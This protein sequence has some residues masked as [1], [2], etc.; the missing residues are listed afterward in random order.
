MS[1]WLMFSFLLT[2]FLSACDLMQARKAK[3]SSTSAEHSPEPTLA[4]SAERAA[5]E[6]TFQKEGK[7][8]STT[9]LGDLVNTHGIEEWEAYDPY[10]KKKK[11]WHTIKL[12]PVLKSM[13]N[14]DVETIRTKSF[15]MKASDGYSVPI[16]GEQLITDDAYLAV[17]DLDFPEW[18]LAGKQKAN[19]GPIY[20][21]WKQS[22]HHDLHEWPRPW[23]L[24]TI[25]LA[26]FEQT[27]PRTIPNE[28]I[29]SSPEAKG[30]EIFKTQCV[31]CHAVNQHGGRLGPE[32]NIPQNI[33]EYRPK[34]QIL[35]YIKNPMTFRYGSMP[36]FEH[37]S[38]QDLE[39]VY[40]YLSVMKNQKWTPEKKEE[41]L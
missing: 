23:Q 21:V 4:L 2:L 11:R 29:A 25:D 30:F 6:L 28:L 10:Y 12:L 13:F 32:L 14:M 27:F 33:T 8:L 41:S 3:E 18:E 34:E 24:T 40:A 38:E 26:S 5:H 17:A 22:E 37:L 20:L 19:P 36:A 15:V 31:R 35:A 7:P 16:A 9:T 1:K 39:H